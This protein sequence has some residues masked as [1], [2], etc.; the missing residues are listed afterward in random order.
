MQ[1][2][3]IEEQAVKIA[4]FNGIEVY[5]IKS[6]K[7]KTNSINIFFIDNL[8]KE[9][10]SKNALVP[11][12]LRR[13]CKSHKTFRDIALYLENLYGASFD[14]GVSKKGEQQIAQF[15]I[16]FLSDTYA[17]KNSGQFEKT[18]ELL[19]EIITNPYL[20]N[21]KF[22][23]DYI[24]QEKDNL[25]KL[26]EG[27]VNDKMQYS[28]DRCF[29]E[30][31]NDEPFGIYEYGTVK[32]VGA[33]ENENLF[34]HYNKM[35]GTYP[36]QVYIAGNFSDSMT[37]KAIDALKMLKRGDILK[38]GKASAAREVTS[39]KNIT[40][41]MSV[42][43]SKLCLGLRTNIPAGNEDYNALMICNGILG[44]GMH[45]KLFQ[46]VREKAS[47]A[48]YAFSRLEKFKSLMVMSAGIEAAN[49]DKTIEIMLKQLEDIRK[50]DI[51][52]YE[53]TS[54]LK[55][56]ETGFKSIRDSQMQMVD[57]YL[58][59]NMT[60]TSESI[61]ATI[62]KL[63]KVKREDIVRVANNIKLDTIY[64]LSE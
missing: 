32:D 46:N 26:I 49:R 51:S 53:H 52:D 6:G 56:L 21:G 28:L 39:V 62:E 5:S 48:Y 41:H 13:G 30:M 4:A 2:T 59:R 64:F 9:N 17:E 45:S 25:S 10:A 15:Y 33:I 60:G 7:F 36:A 40:E 3:L 47:L 16:D 1:A 61:D 22:V 27:R 54:T 37:E 20:E 31:C 11:A 57:F 58:G 12:V 38:T 14:C 55:T 24:N 19:M 44:G 29:E 50:G 43:Q 42:N 18:L 35:I 34:R 23:N 8:S 63:K